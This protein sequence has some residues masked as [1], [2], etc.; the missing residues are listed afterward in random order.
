MEIRSTHKISNRLTT[1]ILSVIIGLI[2]FA[3]K[4]YTTPVE[5]SF[6]CKKRAS[7]I[8]GKKADKDAPTSTSHAFCQ[9]TNIIIDIV[10][11]TE[12]PN[13]IYTG[14]FQY[15]ILKNRFIKEVFIG[16]CPP[17]PKKIV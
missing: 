12:K 6:F 1:M 7:W 16:I 13:I 8:I 3:S 11:I 10:D 14:V 9:S 5:K 4:P 15:N 17:P 2:V